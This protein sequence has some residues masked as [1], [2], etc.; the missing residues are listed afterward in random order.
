MWK[1]IVVVCMIWKSKLWVQYSRSLVWHKSGVMESL[2]VGG[3]LNISAMG[4]EFFNADRIEA[5]VS[6]CS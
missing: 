5:A 6:K 1:R 4:A 3:V 2:T